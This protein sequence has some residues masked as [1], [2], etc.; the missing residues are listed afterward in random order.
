MPPRLNKRQQREQEELLALGKTP[1]VGGG[2]SE[3]EESGFRSKDEID[4]L[5]DSENENSSLPTKARKARKLFYITTRPKK[6]KKKAKAAA[7]PDPVTTEQDS[8][9]SESPRTSQ[10][11]NA[12]PKTTPKKAKAKAKKNDDKDDLDQALAELSVK[13]PELKKIASSPSSSSDFS[14]HQSLASLLAVSLSHLDSEAELRKFFGSKVVIAAKSGSSGTTGTSRRQAGTQRSQLTRPQSSWWPAKLREGLTLRPLT[15]DELEK[16]DRFGSHASG[17]KYWTVEYSKK[18]KSVT[19]AFMQAVMAGDPSAFTPILKKLP[20]H[21]DTL[22]QLSEVYRHQE[23]YSQAVDF[24][25]C[26]L[27]TYERS[28]VGAFSFSTGVNRLDFDRVENRPFFLAL[29]RQATDLQRRGCVR[30]AFEFARLLYSLDPWSDPHGALFHLD[31]LAIKSGMSHWL[32]DIWNEFHSR[33]RGKETRSNYSNPSNLPGWAFARALAIRMREESGKEK[34]PGDSTDALKQAILG[35]PS[36]VVLLADKADITLSSEIRSQK[37]FKIHTDAS[38]LSPAEAVLHAL[39]HLYAQRSAS[40]WK[41]TKYASWF[42]STVAAV[43]PTLSSQRSSPSRDKLLELY[44]SPDARYPVYRHLLVLESSCRS[45]FPFIPREVLNIKQLAC[46]PL[47]PLTSITEYNEEFFKG[48]EDVF[49]IRPRTRRN[50][51]ADQRALERF[52]PD[53]AFRA[54]LQ[55]FFDAHPR[56]AER[57]PEGIVQFVQMLGNLPD[58]VL[59]DMMAAEAMGE[60]G[61]LP[62]DEVNVFLPGIDGIDVDAEDPLQGDAHAEYM[63]EDD[64]DIE[65]EPDDEDGDDEDDEETDIA[66]LPVRVIR[67]LMNRFWGISGHAGN[68]DESSEESGG[69]MPGAGAD[70]VD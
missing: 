41:P 23:D 16:Q 24:V 66:P 60:G 49:A 7:T 44:S 34:S 29:H 40:L 5:D 1:D 21:A 6:K 42:A 50:R 54:Q 69:E 26:A 51:V 10:A 12:N 35:F 19:M 68:D 8:K 14:H 33:S 22:L 17:D 67:N 18:Y 27:F 62:G 37:A 3:D 25:E 63:H 28:F 2:T 31:Y 59:E 15:E 13:Y 36:V 47:P 56:F 43:L 45:L 46:D 64:G 32:L 58:G 53:P 39:S 4:Q 48:S 38:G 20:W 57:F 9:G 30:T 65:D 55:G 61:Q 70:D 11:S 52:L